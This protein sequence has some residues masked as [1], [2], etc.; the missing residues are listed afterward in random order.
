MAS[1]PESASEFEF[2]S[3]SEFSC[4]GDSSSIASSIASSRSLKERCLNSAAAMKERE[5]DERA[6]GR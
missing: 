3:E 6:E 4:P 1:E 2:E 5:I